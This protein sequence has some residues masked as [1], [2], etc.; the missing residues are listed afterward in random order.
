MFT[1]IATESTRP[2]SAGLGQPLAQGQD[3]H[4]DWPR[5]GVDGHET[6][7]QADKAELRP[8]RPHRNCGP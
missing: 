5:H 2:S 6:E 8:E 1:L 3:A 4:I 7:H